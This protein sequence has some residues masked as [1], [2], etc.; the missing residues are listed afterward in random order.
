[1]EKILITGTGRCGT[2]FLI[3]LFSF[4]EFDT[5]FNKDNYF[6]FIH[7][8]C[9][10]GMERY[11]YENHYIIK[12]PDFISN[13]EQIIED[14]SINVKTVIIPVRN[15]TLSALKRIKH[16]YNAG[17]LW[18][19]NDLPSQLQFFKDIMSNYVYIMTKYNINTIFINFDKMICDK[20]YLFDKLNPILIEKNI[21]FEKFSQVYDE[22]SITSRPK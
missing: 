4:L 7:K 12:S 22:V 3:K 20:K 10:S 2:T 8:N 15:Y 13:I 16:K 19:A 11:Y 6:N 14:P 18:N 1:M 17:G 5:G 21:D 9:N